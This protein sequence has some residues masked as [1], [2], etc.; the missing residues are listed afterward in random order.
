M[1]FSSIGRLWRGSIDVGLGWLILMT[2]GVAVV[3]AAWA[4]VAKMKTSFT[5]LDTAIQVALLSSFCT[6]VG[7]LLSKRYEGSCDLRRERMHKRW[8]T[9]EAVVSYL[10]EC[11]QREGTYITLEKN[12]IESRCH[13]TTQL[14]LMWASESVQVEWEKY[15]AFR[16][17][18]KGGQMAVSR[19]L[20]RIGVELG[21]RY[22][23]G[24]LAFYRPLRFFYGCKDVVVRLDDDYDKI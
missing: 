12:E 7:F 6:C 10:F 8:K 24:S 20:N 14:V 18:G 13:D 19:L 15:L 17:S 2:V 16:Q 22:S 3:I 23:T 5:G 1:K 9:Y 21:N 4:V 11:Q